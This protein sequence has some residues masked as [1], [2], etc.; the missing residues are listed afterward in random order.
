[1]K[2]LFDSFPYIENRR[3]LLKNMDESDVEALLEM[4]K[5]ENVYRYLPKFL[6]EQQYDDKFEV[7]YH[8]NSDKF[9][10]KEAILLGVYL[11]ETNNQF[12]G[13]AEIY[14]Y[15]PALAKVTIGYRLADP[16]WGKGI[17]TE[18][19]SLIV[20]YLFKETDI[21][22]IVASHISDNPASG[23][24]LKKNRFTKIDAYAEEDWGYK[25]KARVDRWS[26]TKSCYQADE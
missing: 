4:T 22:V 5:S 17:A 21:E 1:M 23:K 24:V 13:I 14:H 26:L 2:V 15:D 9:E 3:I 20:Q 16:Y 11:K 12:C 8:C 7:I 25:E 18:I 19:V 6:I 10:A